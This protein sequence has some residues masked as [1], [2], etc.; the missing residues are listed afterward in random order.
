MPLDTTALDRDLA[1]ITADLPVT[2]TVGGVS[3]SVSAADESMAHDLELA[4]YADDFDVEF[5][6][7]V[8]VLAMPAIGTKLNYNA[9]TYRVQ[10]TMPSPDGISYR[11]QCKE[12]SQR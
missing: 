12:E 5:T 9:R 3:Y 2:I 6:V 1:E 11:M 10:K 7:R 8:S 4:G